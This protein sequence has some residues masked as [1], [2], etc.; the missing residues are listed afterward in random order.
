M[1]KMFPF[2]ARSPQA[3]SLEFLLGVFNNFLF[4]EPRVKSNRV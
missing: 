2:V 1:N 4:T 3:Q